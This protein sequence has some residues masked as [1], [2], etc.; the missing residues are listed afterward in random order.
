MTLTIWWQS[1]WDLCAF[2]NVL[3][4][5]CIGQEE[6]QSAMKRNLK[7]QVINLFL[8]FFIQLHSYIVLWSDKFSKHFV[9]YSQMHLKSVRMFRGS[10]I[11]NQTIKLFF[12]CI[13]IWLIHAPYKLSYAS[14]TRKSIKLNIFIRTYMSV[15]LASTILNANILNEYSIVWFTFH[16]YLYS[17]DIIF[18]GYIHTMN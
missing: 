12:L 3:M 16:L 7:K 15:W 4:C 17:V 9:L 1:E 10:W 6:M 18:G 11:L 8:F 13:Y 14:M 5:E 2:M